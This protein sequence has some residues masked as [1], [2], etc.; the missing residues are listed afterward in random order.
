MVNAQVQAAIAAVPGST[1]EAYEL[2]RRS[3]DG[4][5]T[6]HPEQTASVLTPKLR[7]RIL[8]AQEAEGRLDP[9]ELPQTRC[10]A[11]TSEDI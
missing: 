11:G 3:F 7:A 9:L 1:L 6:N 10:G 8:S 4:L 5:D 2:P